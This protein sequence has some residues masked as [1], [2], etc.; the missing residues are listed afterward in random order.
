LEGE[1]S[2]H[3]SPSA[4]GLPTLV[5]NYSN[6]YGPYDFPEKLVPLVIL[7]ALESKLLLVYCK[8]HHIRWLYVEDNAR[9][10]LKV[11]TEGALL[12]THSKTGAPSSQLSGRD[13]LR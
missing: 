2:Q 5:T 10:L 1:Q 4:Q 9:A 7:N 13:H 12:A 8:R 11:V 6:N 3:R